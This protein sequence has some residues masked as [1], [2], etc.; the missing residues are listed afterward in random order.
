MVCTGTT[1][2]RGGVTTP[3]TSN[4]PGQRKIWC[5]RWSS[6]GKITFVPCITNHIQPLKIYGDGAR[7]IEVINLSALQYFLDHDVYEAAAHEAESDPTT[8]AWT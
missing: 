5:N 4:Q 2:H 1:T 7:S 8:G 6:R 3:P